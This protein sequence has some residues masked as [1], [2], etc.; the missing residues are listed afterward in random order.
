MITKSI[1]FTVALFFLLLA[2]VSHAADVD[3][4][5]STSGGGVD[6]VATPANTPL[7]SASNIVPGQDI[8]RSISIQNDHNDNC[9]MR[10]AT[11][12][13]SATPNDFPETLFTA[14]VSGADTYGASNGSGGAL[15]SKKLSDLFAGDIANLGT[16]TTGSNRTYDWI[17]TFD[18]TAGNAYQGATASFDFDLN[19]ECEEGGGS[20]GGQT[21]PTPTPTPAPTSSSS[22][23]GDGGGGSDENQEGNGSVLGT[24][25]KAVAPK[26][27]ASGGTPVVVSEVLGTGTLAATGTFVDKVLYVLL[28]LGVMITAVSGHNLYRRHRINHNA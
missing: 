23:S 11:D 9:L 8:A 21:D 3:V 18:T 14:I 22:S 5:C 26:T 6:C 20:G 1:S 15:S 2:G 25:S 7:F 12:D 28:V 19:F 27:L 16:V 4:T 10:M 17:V 24:I 13:A